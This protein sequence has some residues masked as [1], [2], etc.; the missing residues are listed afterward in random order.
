MK[1]TIEKQTEN[2]ISFL[3]LFIIS[4]GDNILTSVY[5]KRQSIAFKLGK[6]KELLEKNLY[7]RNIINQ[8]L[9]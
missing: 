2:Q 1:F 7:S 9:N 3:D 4:N 8:Q 5:R 6:T